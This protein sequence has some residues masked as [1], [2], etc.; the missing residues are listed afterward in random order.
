MFKNLH[1]CHLPFYST[2][3]LRGKSETWRGWM[4]CTVP[5]YLSWESKAGSMGS[6]PHHLGNVTDPRLTACDSCNLHGLVRGEELWDIQGCSCLTWLGGWMDLRPRRMRPSLFSDVLRGTTKGLSPLPCCNFFLSHLHPQLYTPNAVHW[7]ILFPSSVPS[8]WMFGAP[9]MCVHT[10]PWHWSL[11]SSSLYGLG[12]D[13]YRSH[14]PTGEVS[15]A[16]WHT[17]D[18]EAGGLLWV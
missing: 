3:S 7:Y 5:G 14:N 18:V 11:S 17:A 2:H 1:K 13:V 12:A 4:F 8:C 16:W 9:A 6:C 10:L 15:W